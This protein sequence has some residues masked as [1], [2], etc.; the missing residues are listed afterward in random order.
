MKR[1]TLVFILLMSSIIIYA[2]QINPPLA[3]RIPFEIKT[4]HGN[5]RTD[6]YYWMKN[7]DDKN[8][9]DYLKAENSYTES[10]MASTKPLQQKLINEMRSRIKDE[11]T[12]LPYKKGDYFYYSRYEA[13]K[14]YEIFCRKNDRENAVEEIIVDGNELAK[15]QV[16]LSFEVEISPDQ[17]KACVMM[18]VKGRNFFT[19]KIKD[20]STGKWLKDNIENTRNGVAWANDNASFVYA[21][22]DKETLRV[23]QVKKHILGQKQNKDKLLYQEND[24]TLDCYVYKSRSEKYIF[25]DVERTD[26]SAFYYLEADNPD[27]V[28]TAVKF[29]AG[30]YNTVDHT[31]GDVFFIKTNYHAPNYKLVKSKI[32]NQNIQEWVDVIAERQD[33][34]LQS[35]EFF[36]D[37]TVLEELENGLIQLHVINKKGQN[38]LIDFDEAGYYASLGYNPDFNQPTFRYVYS[39]LIS[40]FTV[41][42]FNE[43]TK[44]KK[45][46]K[47]QDVPGYDKSQYKTERFFV[48]ARD[49][50]KVPVTVVYRTDKFKKNGTA[51]GLIYGYGAY[52]SSTDDYFDSNVFS[53][54]DRGFVFCNTH[55]RGGSEMGGAWYEDGKML[56]KKN[57]FFDFID[58]SE[59]L[60]KNNY[61][62][63]DKLFA[64]GLS[65]GG[66]LMGAIS[67]FRPD[68][69]RGIIADVPFVDVMTTME[70]ASIPL[71]SFEWLEWG[72]PAIKEQYDYM[73]SYSPYDNV[74]AKN[75]PNMLVTTGLN[76]SQVQYFEPAKWVA[77]LRYLKTDNNLLL[78]KINMDAGHGGNSGR[79]E[80]LNDYAVFYAFMLNILGINE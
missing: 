79:Y 55:I 36:K 25:I 42:D 56:H 6:Y 22:P 63:K 72:N 54:L 7:R 61:V 38:Y 66:L 52:G 77:K 67:N 48:T 46:L 34:F 14:D 17:K 30:I 69:Y 4:M 29:E 21:V 20:L 43:S 33:V 47:Q 24:E 19:I 80:M 74:A 49:G 16:F 76:D 26:A 50:K 44:E 8:V 35:I 71:T 39:S 73:Y 5:T 11:E 3:E 51:P 28:Q 60:I 45:L 37:F 18:D 31:D 23:F 59:W 78:F 27:K 70:D 64:N 10:M 65:A 40:P 53:L 15:G 58:C 2:Q 75:Y 57:T 13:G 41:Y 9:I 12:E 68:L 32:G 62:A 1:T